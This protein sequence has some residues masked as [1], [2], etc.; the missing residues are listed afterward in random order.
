MLYLKYVIKNFCLAV[1]SCYRPGP[2]DIGSGMNEFYVEQLLYG[3][4]MNE[5]Y[6]EQITLQNVV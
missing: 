2:S 1:Y 3:S 6:V 5:F 4:G